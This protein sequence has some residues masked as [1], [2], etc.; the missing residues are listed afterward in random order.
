MRLDVQVKGKPVAQLY[1]KAD[2]YVLKYNADA[3]PEDFVSLTMPV[4]DDP[5]VWPRDLHPFFRQNLPEGFLLQVIRDE[6]GPYLDGTDLSLL[7]V[8]GGAGIGRVTVTPEGGT[9]GGALEPLDVAHLLH[10]DNTAD[11]FAQL[12]RQYARAAISGAVPKF[13]APEVS[14]KEGPLGKP[15]LRT[16][17]HIIKGSD[18]N[19]P[20]LGFNEHYSMQV[21]ARLG[22]ARVANTTMSDDGRILVVD[23]FDVDGNGH[24]VYGVE[25]S[26]SLLGYPPHE[27]YRPTTEQVRK[28]TSAYIT[29]ANARIEAEQFGW[30]LLTNYVVR[31]ADCHSKNI[32]VFYP[33]RDDVV[34]TPAYDIVT[35]QAYS[36]FAKNPP[37]LSVAGRKTWAPGKTLER[38]FSGTLGIPPKTYLAMVEALCDSAVAVGKEIVEVS[39]NEP[40]WHWVAK[41]M[42]HAW[43]EGMA[44]LRSN[45]PQASLKSLTPV[46]DAAG[47]SDADKADNTRT[48]IGRSE[49][50]GN[51]HKSS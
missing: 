7:A 36:R 18:E 50:L 20:Y 28:A 24:P 11:H 3:A 30:L 38:F 43:N 51:P 48:V 27:K 29:S 44:T 32:A 47:F 34:Y 25:D 1:R 31:N 23:R 49:L 22:V 9:P 10:R 45:K 14:E 6:F 41:Q 33:D 40:R 16:S 21:L 12:V 5:W 46:I 42:L 15:T 13:L 35:T 17:R 39:R 19:T 4:Q 37:G 8:V 26:C 2:D